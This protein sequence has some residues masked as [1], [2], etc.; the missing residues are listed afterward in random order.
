MTA[1]GATGE[2]R[3]ARTRQD[4]PEGNHVGDIPAVLTPRRPE[5]AK[6]QRKS[7]RICHERWP[8][9]D[10]SDR[11]HDHRRDQQSKMVSETYGSEGETPKP[12][13]LR[14]HPPLAA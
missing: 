4:D 12:E 6:H 9:A 3:Q 14:R 2:I 8:P 5:C 7:E 1:K 10:Q 11:A 13:P